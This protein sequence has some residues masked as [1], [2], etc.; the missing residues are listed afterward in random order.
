MNR[1]GRD[2]AISDQRASNCARAGMRKVESSVDEDITARSATFA[3]VRVWFTDVVVTVRL[4]Y[5]SE[6]C[7]TLTWR[8]LQPVKS[9]YAFCSQFE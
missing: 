3:R 9:C 6:E 1:A 7:L 5:M 4:A 2:Q 8:D